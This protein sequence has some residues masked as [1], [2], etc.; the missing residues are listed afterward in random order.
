MSKAVSYY[1]WELNFRNKTILN[2]N[3][4][5]GKKTTNYKDSVNSLGLSDHTFKDVMEKWRMKN[6]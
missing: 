1:D 6:L 3:S 4:K 5:N 2:I